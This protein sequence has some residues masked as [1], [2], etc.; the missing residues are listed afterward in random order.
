MF[1]GKE[2]IFRHCVKVLKKYNEKPNRLEKTGH[3]TAVLHA[4]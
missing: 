1:S 3:M 4:R 2:I